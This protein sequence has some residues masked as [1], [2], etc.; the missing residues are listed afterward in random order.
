MS[1]NDFIAENGMPT[2][3]GQEILYDLKES[4]AYIFYEMG[5][6]NNDTMTEQELTILGSVLMKELAELIYAKKQEIIKRDLPDLTNPIWRM[7]DAE[8]ESFM[9]NKYGKKWTLL[10]VE[11]EEQK[12]YVKMVAPRIQ[13]ALAKVAAEIKQENQGYNVP[14][15]NIY[16]K[17]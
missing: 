7:E 16:F 14:P 12:R 4:L 2:K 9:R 5:G 6:Q 8:F 1:F 10:S 17:A 13:E 11:P 3:K 15:N